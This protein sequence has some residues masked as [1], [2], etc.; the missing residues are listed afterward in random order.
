MFLPSFSFFFYML[1]IFLFKNI[2]P[3]LTFGSPCCQHCLNPLASSCLSFHGCVGEKAGFFSFPWIWIRVDT[4]ASV[5]ACGW[6][7][8]QL[9]ASK[10]AAGVYLFTFAMARGNQPLVR[11]ALALQAASSARD[12]HS[13]PSGSEAD[14]LGCVHCYESTSCWGL[15]ESC[16]QF[17]VQIPHF[18]PHN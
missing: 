8:A 12:F 4:C 9:G 5:H 1:V 15:G 7:G 16:H 3:N 2:F 14:G 6:N 13:C 18:L 11:I 17:L 10:L